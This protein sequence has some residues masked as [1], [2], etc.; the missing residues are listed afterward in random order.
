M[1]TAGSGDA[2]LGQTDVPINN[3][4][5]LMDRRAQECPH[6][7]LRRAVLPHGGAGGQETLCL[8][9]GLP[10]SLVSVCLSGHDGAALGKR[11]H[12]LFSKNPEVMELFNQGVG[13]A[14]CWR[15]KLITDV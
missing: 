3:L 12:L 14:S 8:P 1:L 5:G 2:T 10:G 9:G 13:A 15:K 7:Y 6:A 4:S 11:T